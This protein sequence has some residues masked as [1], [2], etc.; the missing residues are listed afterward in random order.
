VLASERHAEHAA[1]YRYERRRK[2]KTHIDLKE[3]PVAAA[4]LA[5]LGVFVALGRL[6][7]V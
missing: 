2:V 5:L 4:I 7:V 3:S 6:G 1:E